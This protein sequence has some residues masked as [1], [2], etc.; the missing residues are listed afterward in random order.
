MYSSKIDQ[1]VNLGFHFIL[2]FF[3]NFD[4]ICSS[5]YW[6]SLWTDTEQRRKNNEPLNQTFVDRCSPNENI[7]IYG[8][9]MFL[10]FCF[11]LFRGTIFFVLCMRA[12]VRLHNRLFKKLVRAPMVFFET[13]PIGQILNRFSR[14]TG[15][16]DDILPLTGNNLKI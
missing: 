9:Q 7:A 4:L 16:I 14:D 12:S 13:N 10:L 15:I 2:I 11:S 1:L 5:D 6:L 3:Y 8:T